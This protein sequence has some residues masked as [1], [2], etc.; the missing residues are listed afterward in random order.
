MNEVL[1]QPTLH[2]AE[3][4]IAYQNKDITA[5]YLTEGLKGKTLKAYGLPELKIIDIHP[6]NLPAIEA[7]ELRIDNILTFSDGS[8]GIIDYESS[9]TWEDKVKHINYVA[10]ILKR[11]ERDGTIQN[12]T[13]IRLIIIFTA[14]IQKVDTLVLDV[15]CMKVYI[16]PAY[17]VGINT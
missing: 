6:T 13:K 12:I 3:S 8:I 14:D 1:K 4:E 16:E 9:Y 2:E 10:R 11:H 15:G 7:N 5:K 17:L